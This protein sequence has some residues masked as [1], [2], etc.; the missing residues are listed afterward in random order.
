M[1][2]ICV[3]AGTTEG[4]K[5]V[6]FLTGQGAAVTACVAT[7]YGEALLSP[8]ETLT[9]RTG[10]LSKAE[11]EALFAAEQFD[12]VVDATHPYAREVTENLVEAC[13]KTDTEYLRMIRE[14]GTDFTRAV[15]VGTAAE[16]AEFLRGTEGK[17]LLTTGSK[18]LSAFSALPDFANRVYVRVLP[19]ADSLELCEKAGVLRSH[20]FAMQGPFSTE[21]NEALLR[22]TDSRWLVTKESGNA[23]GF[24]E[25]IEAALAVG[26]TPVVIGRPKEENGRTF[27]QSLSYLCG[28]FG[29]SRKPKVRICGIGPGN[30]EFL[31]IQVR[32][33]IREADCLIGAGR[34]LAGWGEKPSFPAIAPGEIAEI[35]EKHKE[36]Q[37]F[38]VL[39]SGDTG[40][41]SGAKKLLP[42]LGNCEVQVCP[43]LS[44]MQYLCSRVGTSWEDIRPVSL[45]GRETDVGA[46]LRRNRRI[47]VLVGGED[48]VGKLCR[49]LC[50]AGY[51]TA[52]LTVGERLSYPDERIRIGTPET[53]EAERF[54]SL[55]AVLV[56]TEEV[57]VV[58]HGLPD[59]A[60]ERRSGAGGVIPMT[61]RE[62]RSVC[63][64]QLEL[65]RDSVCWDVGAGTGSVSVEMA[66]LA[67]EGRVYAMEQRPEAVELIR[68]NAERFHVENLTVVPGKAPESC[69]RLPAPSHVFIGGSS[70]NLPEILDCILEKNPEARIVA[71]A[72]SLE[73]IAALQAQ[74]SRFEH[75]GVCALTVARDRKVG[76]YTLMSGQNPIYL[77]TFQGGKTR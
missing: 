41:F 61:K 11:M 54:H 31:T 57:P 77:F 71:T 63:L 17:I 66:L 55:S 45:H 65:R 37:T 22:S 53:L 46:G 4:R 35:I 42:L 72:L 10:R 58:T 15:S 18:E 70:G 56:E 50:A 40:F 7:E 59:E 24:D 5:I 19:M 48:G 36:F 29:F 75:T 68:E 32:D 21:M 20:I 64:S 30:R 2:K 38:A 47:F 62:V 6:G 13:R 8:A 49:Q 33:A 3:F 34:M 26:A 23:G 39:M 14:N 44:S 73:T 28:K 25:K 67:E 1:C 43:G 74:S 51:E 52:K 9:V 16:A 76:G 27:A 69:A 12:L 60:F